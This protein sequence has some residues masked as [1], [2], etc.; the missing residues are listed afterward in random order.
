MVGETFGCLKV[1]GR[2]PARG[3]NAYWYVRCSVCN[4][5][6]AR[7]AD[8][9]RGDWKSCGCV[10]A[11]RVHGRTD[12]P[13]HN[14]WMSMRARCN[15]QN[16]I[17]YPNYGGRGITVFDRWNAFESFLADMGECPSPE[18]SLERKN[19]DLGY[20]PDNCRWATRVEQ[21]NNKRTNVVL[22]LGD[23]S[24]TLAQ[25]ARHKGVGY[26]A[27]WARV[28]RYGAERALTM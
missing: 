8:T 26:K 28:S 25:W 19:N 11:S 1:T 21:A 4:R 13:T 2:A 20:S 22:T 17:S 9:L 10:A 12:T 23:Q 14:V 6:K 18:H 15:D 27:M 24:M 3:K 16:N 5:T 7:R